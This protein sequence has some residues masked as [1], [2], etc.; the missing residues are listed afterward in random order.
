MC[1]SCCLLAQNVFVYGD[2]QRWSLR[3]LDMSTYLYLH[4]KHFYF[5]SQRPPAQNK[6][7]ILNNVQWQIHFRVAGLVVLLSMG[8]KQAMLRETWILR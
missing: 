4:T 1:N 3:G 7:L 2:W 6:P 5:S 8:F